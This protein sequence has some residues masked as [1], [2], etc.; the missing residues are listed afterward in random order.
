MRNNAPAHT[1]PGVYHARYSTPR[2]RANNADV[3][4]AQDAAAELEGGR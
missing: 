3:C 1:P 4:I 2:S